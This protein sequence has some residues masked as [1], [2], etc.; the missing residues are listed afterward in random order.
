MGQEPLG[1]GPLVSDGSMKALS[2][3]APWWWAILHGKPVE[4]RDWYTSQRGPI[5]LHASKWWKTSEVDD[6]WEDVLCM[7]ELDGITMP[8]STREAMRAAGGCIVGSVEIVDCIRTNTIKSA[9][10][11]GEYGFVL[12]NPVALAKPIPFKGALGFFDVP[13]GV[14]GDAA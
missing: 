6:D 7:A 9:F 1:V 4:N 8:M 2:I 12:R 5:W 11:M 3:R 10:F 13:D 14:I